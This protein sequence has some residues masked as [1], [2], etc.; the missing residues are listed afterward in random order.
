M[1]NHTHFSIY[2]YKQIKDWIAEPFNDH[3]LTNYLGICMV[4]H[5]IALYYLK[6]KS[7]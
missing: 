2:S 6:K 1:I 5:I 7:K 4:D 3:V